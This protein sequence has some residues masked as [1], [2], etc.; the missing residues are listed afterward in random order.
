L[1]RSEATSAGSIWSVPSAFTGIGGLIENPTSRKETGETRNPKWKLGVKRSVTS[2]RTRTSLCPSPPGKTARVRFWR[3]LVHTHW[4][5]A[6]T[7]SHGAIRQPT[8]SWVSASRTP[9]SM[10]EY[11]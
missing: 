7:R 9:E 6:P 8:L 2:K 11:R 3:A 5:E 1:A 4:K 10:S